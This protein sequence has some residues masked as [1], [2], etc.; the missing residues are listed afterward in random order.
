MTATALILVYPLLWLLGAAVVA[1]V[2]YLVVRRGVRDGFL[3]AR[4]LDAEEA[5]LRRPS[6]AGPPTAPPD[7]P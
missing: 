5:A 1:F 6:A 7:A 2:L 4:Q 3:D